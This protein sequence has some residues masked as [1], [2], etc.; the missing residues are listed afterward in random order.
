MV[1]QWKL[2]IARRSL[3]FPAGAIDNGSALANAKRELLEETGFAGGQWRKLGVV[4]PDTGRSRNALHVFAAR[5]VTRV[6]EPT[7]D[8]MERLCG[9]RV[10]EVG[11]VE[12]RSMVVGG[13]IRSSG[14]LAALAMLTA[15]GSF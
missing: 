8:A 6:G 3:E 11:R 12:L 1:E 4:F 5:G 14:S 2:P 13:H 10:R 15:R 7:P 9:I